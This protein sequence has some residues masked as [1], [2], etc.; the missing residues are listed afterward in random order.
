MRLLFLL[1]LVC[2]SAGAQPPV[3]R[4][5]ARR[6]TGPIVI[7]G[8]LDDKAWAAAG[9]VAVAAGSVTA[10]FEPRCLLFLESE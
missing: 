10:A 4:Y 3:P 1:L 8:K 5:D 2:A 7:D 6:A 9:T